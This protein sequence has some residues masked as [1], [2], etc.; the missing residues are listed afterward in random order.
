MPNSRALMIVMALSFALPALASA[1]GPE[2]YRAFAV[3]LSNVGT[4]TN[5]TVD[6][7]IERWSNDA[8]KARLFEALQKSPEALLSALQAVTPRVGFIQ[9]PGTTGWDLR[10]A[11]KVRGEDGGWQIVVATDRPIG[12]REAVERP[13]TFDYPF[14]LI[15][16][17]VNDDG[18]GEGRASVLTKITW[19]GE[20]RTLE[21][22][23][24]ATEPVRLQALK[25]IQ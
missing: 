10:Y 18:V 24:Y 1:Q 15:E 11:N 21:L 19:D 12:F 2:R 4:G 14:T 6:I 13:R 23:N 9:L 5:T 25:K 20:S 22:E 16:M 7:V 8:E 17:H 3:N